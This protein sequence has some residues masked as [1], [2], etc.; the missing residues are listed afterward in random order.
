MRKLSQLI[1]ILLKPFLKHIQSFIRD[2][3]DSLK[4]FP[5]DVDEDNELVTFDV[6]GL[7]TSIPHEFGLESI[8]Y[9]LTKYQE[10]Y[11]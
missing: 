9:F 6:I 8:D 10:T 4:K 11:I 5:R 2:S 3:L 1:D 7:Y